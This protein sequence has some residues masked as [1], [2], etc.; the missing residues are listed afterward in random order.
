MDDKKNDL[1]PAVIREFKIRDYDAL[2]ALWT[3]AGLPYRPE[4]RDARAEMERQAKEPTA[5]YLVAEAEGE[6]VGAVLGTH[7]G[8]K[9]WINRLAVSPPYRRR[10]L[11]GELLAEVERRL[12]AL[13]IGIFAC[14]VE[15]WNAD[16]K[17]FFEK[18][19]YKPF[20]GITYFT[21]RRRADV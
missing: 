9:G 11:G 21:K 14:L 20:S 3:S 13:G 15:D 5:I 19:G 4:G 7:D 16:S 1:S 2:L 18:S 12:A 17:G 8:R 10:G 6:I